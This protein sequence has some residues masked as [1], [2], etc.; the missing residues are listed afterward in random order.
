MFAHSILI[1]NS[2]FYSYFSEWGYLKKLVH[3]LVR[4]K[5]CTNSI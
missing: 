1:A 2:Y 5:V 4:T 3:T